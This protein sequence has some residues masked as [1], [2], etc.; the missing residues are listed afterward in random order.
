VLHV[1]HIICCPYYRFNVFSCAFNLT[2]PL[3][4]PKQQCVSL[5]PKSV[6]MIYR[7]SI[8]LFLKILLSQIIVTPSG[9]ELL[10]LRSKQITRG[11]LLECKFL[12]NFCLPQPS[13]PSTSGTVKFHLHLWKVQPLEGDG[14]RSKI[15]TKQPN[16]YAKWGSMLF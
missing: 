9:V 10:V 7:L 4:A 3:L 6:S 2:F 1:R 16:P 15:W 12:C 14:T 11:I 8:L 13:F 5:I